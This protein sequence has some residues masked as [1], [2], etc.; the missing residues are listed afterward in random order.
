MK[1]GI[2]RVFLISL[3]LIL[4]GITAGIV[5]VQ[6]RYITPVAQW[7]IQQIGLPEFHAQKISYQYP[8]HLKFEHVTL[9]QQL[10]PIQTVD[11]WLNPYQSTLNQLMFDSVLIDGLTLDNEQASLPTPLETVKINQL[12][13]RN[14]AVETTDN[15][16]IHGLN[17][18]IQNPTWN[19]TSTYLPYGDIQLY[20]SQ[21]MWQGETLTD[22]LITGSHQAQHSQINSLTATWRGAS[23]SLQGKTDGQRWSIENLT[24]DK[25]NL[26]LSQFQQLSDK[27][28]DLIAQHIAQIDRLDLL[29]SQLNMPHVQLNNFDLSLTDF[30]PTASESLWKQ[31]H[32]V[33][34]LDAESLVLDDMMLVEPSINLILTPGQLDIDDFSSTL[35][36]GQIHASGSIT[37][38][39]VTIRDL[40]IQSMKMF[41]ESGSEPDFT[42]LASLIPSFRQ[43]NVEQ[44]KI[45]NS[46]IIQLA[47]QPYWQLSG[48]NTDIDHAQLIDAQRWGLWQ[49]TARMSVNN[50]SY[51]QFVVSQGLV[52]MHSQEN[53]WVL[54]RLFLPF[55]KGYLAA[56]GQWQYGLKGAPWQF[57][58][59][60]DSLPLNL[61][62]HLPLQMK[63]LA[64]LSGSAQGLSGDS[65][66]INHTLSGLLNLDIRNG[67]LQLPDNHAQPKDFMLNAMEITGDR[68]KI[69][70]PEIHLKSN[71]LN[72]TISG[73]WDLTQSDKGSLTLSVT[74]GEKQ[75]HYNLLEPS[76]AV[77]PASQTKTGPIQETPDSSAN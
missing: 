72:A 2:I 49:G 61:F 32:A 10:A 7:M 15:L 54:D 8:F 50:L 77:P 37:P 40:Q 43:V 41:I 3:L 23:F 20:A 67:Q 6:S 22:L 56:K 29:N 11:I 4:I 62:K 60:A 21:V 25:L 42:W 74:S 63:G 55:S 24:T 59:D 39:T 28:K 68:G 65:V 45:R 5:I 18:Q 30:H 75:T 36:D 73:R 44:L 46:Q 35:M 17:V 66:I 19:E 57:S 12:A 76:Q 27:F 69:T 33:L 16:M 70:V 52:E 51:G 47:H 9:S 48:I 34:S 38:E 31:A 1:T 58:I 14:L 53:N 71:D 64:D 26:S 13:I